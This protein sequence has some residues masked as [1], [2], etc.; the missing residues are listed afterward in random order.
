MAASAPKP[1]PFAHPADI[2]RAYQKDE[3]C[4]GQ[5]RQQLCE[6]LEEVLGHRRA[7]P[8]QS[9]MA[10]FADCAYAAATVFL[11]GRTLGE[12]YCELLVV[13]THIRRVSSRQRALA[14]VLALLP[15]AALKRFAPDSSATAP[16][17]LGRRLLKRIVDAVPVLLRIHLGAFYLFGAFRQLS[18]RVA[19]IR[20]L[21]LS[22]RPQRAFSYRPLGALLLAQIVGQ[23]VASYFQWRR[24]RGS[25]AQQTAI[26]TETVLAMSGQ[27]KV[28][29]EAGGDPDRQPICYICYC[30]ADCATGTP[31]GHI[32]CWDCIG[33]WCAIKASCPLCR[34]ACLPQQLLPLRHYEVAP[35][36]AG[37]DNVI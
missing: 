12:E 15:L 24:E 5:L 11:S 6:T 10:L 8:W 16:R 1:L 17:G 18:D 31:C 36:G 35:P 3:Q 21:S 32:F 2:V 7:A 28:K 9:T 30:P 26:A 37:R 25:V 14:A 4:R 33:G 23:A 34:S 13:T 19:G 20:Y 22:E 27:G 29:L